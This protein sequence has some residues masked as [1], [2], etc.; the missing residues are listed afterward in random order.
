MSKTEKAAKPEKSA[1]VMVMNNQTH[2]VFYPG[3]KL[4]PGVNKVSRAAAEAMKKNPHI[5]KVKGISVTDAPPAT[6]GLDIDDAV[7][8]VE[9]TYDPKLVQEF[10][11]EDDRP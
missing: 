10:L 4:S 6:K 8:L 2:T 5:K 7:E 3:W 1:T 9:K 11:S